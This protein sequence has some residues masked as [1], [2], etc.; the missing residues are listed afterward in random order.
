[1]LY[2]PVA[3]AAQRINIV[4]HLCPAASIPINNASH[5]SGH[6]SQHIDNASQVMRY[7][8]QRV[9]IVCYSWRPAIVPRKTFLLFSRYV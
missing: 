1:M 4:L 7:A 5:L 8:A 3:H 2:A 6:A 9:N